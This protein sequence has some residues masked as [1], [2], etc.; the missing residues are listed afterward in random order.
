MSNAQCNYNIHDKELLA[1]LQAF[2]EWKRYTRGS[3]KPARVLTDHKNL[4]PF[5]T[6]KEAK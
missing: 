1:T 3:W 4:V 6:M 2:H 5:M